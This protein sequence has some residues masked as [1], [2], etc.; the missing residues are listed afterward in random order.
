MHDLCLLLSLSLS[1]SVFVCLPSALRTRSKQIVVSVDTANTRKYLSCRL[2]RG[3]ETK[4]KRRDRCVS[5]MLTAAY[6]YSTTIACFSSRFPFR[7]PS[8]DA[9]V[10]VQLQKES[11][12]SVFC[13][14]VPFFLSCSKWRMTRRAAFLSARHTRC[15]VGNIGV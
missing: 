15:L 5:F 4:R 8:E 14:S 12:C 11:N 3:K 2:S 9:R 7:K 6:S 10:C 13:L 1:L